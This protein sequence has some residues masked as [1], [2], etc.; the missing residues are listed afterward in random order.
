VPEDIE[1]DP[2][3]DPQIRGA[4]KEPP[5]GLFHIRIGHQENQVFHI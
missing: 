3:A 5:H 1:S 2:C 4:G